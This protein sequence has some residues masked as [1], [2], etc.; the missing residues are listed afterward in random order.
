MK[1][2]VRALSFLAAAVMTGSALTAS[3]P[4][5]LVQGAAPA[6][7]QTERPKA[8]TER[9]APAAATAPQQTS[10]TVRTTGTVLTETAVTT[11]Q[12]APAATTKKPAVTTN[13]AVTTKPAAQT[14]R[15]VS[16]TRTTTTTEQTTTTVVT[17]VPAPP[18]IRMSGI[19]ADS[20]VQNTDEWNVSADNSALFFK[21]LDEEPENESG[22]G[23][24]VDR[25][26]QRW[27][28]ASKAAFDHEGDCWIHFWAVPSNFGQP[29]GQATF[30]Y[31]L[32]AT[33]PEAY[34]LTPTN[35]WDGRAY[36]EV[37]GSGLTD[38]VSG[39]NRIF[40]D[41]VKND[42]SRQSTG[43]SVDPVSAEDGTYSISHKI[44]DY[45]QPG[46]SLIFHVLDQAGN[47]RTFTVLGANDANKPVIS[48][49][50]NKLC[51]NRNQTDKAVYRDFGLYQNHKQHRAVFAGDANACLRVQVTEENLKK[52]TVRVYTLN[53]ETNPSYETVT[54]YKPGSKQDEAHEWIQK[55]KAQSGDPDV[56]FLPVSKLGLEEGSVYYFA[57]EAE[58]AS[59]NTSGF[60]TIMRDKTNTGYLLYDPKGTT[61]SVIGMRPDVKPVQYGGQYYYGADYAKRSLTVDLSDDYGIADYKVAVNGTEIAA[62]NLSGGVTTATYYT[63]VVPVTDESGEP[64]TD[65]DDGTETTV[66]TYTETYY[67]PVKKTS[68]SSLRLS[69]GDSPFRA[70]EQHQI[71]VQLNDLAGNKRELNYPLVIDTRAPSVQD[72]SYRYSGDLLHYLTF[73]I[74]GHEKLNL[75]IT[76]DDGRNGIGVDPEQVFLYWAPADAETDELT[77]YAPEPDHSGNVFRFQDLPLENEAIPYFTIAD[78]LGN[79]RT[80][81]FEIA[82]DD[83]KSGKLTEKA[84]DQKSL[85]LENTPPAVKLITPETYLPPET[86]AAESGLTTT[87]PSGTTT[88]PAGAA[89]TAPSGVTTSVPSGMTTTAPPAETTAAPVYEPG[90]DQLRVYEAEGARWYPGPVTVDVTARDRNS[91]IAEVL[92]Y[93]K[94]TLL[95]EETAFPASG[96]SE[97]AA[98]LYQADEEGNISF[99]ANRFVD[100]LLYHYRFTEEGSY[101]LRA[102]AYDNAGNWNETARAVIHL[103]LHN[104]KILRFRIGDKTAE[105]PFYERDTFGYFF[106]ED[107]DVRVYI[108]DE[109]VS[110]GFEAVELYLYERVKNEDGTY[111][112]KNPDPVTVSADKLERDEETGQL[113]A[114]FTVRRN[115]KGK[116]AAV[117]RDNVGHSSGLTYTDGNVLEDEEQHEKDSGITI[118]EQVRLEKRDAEGILLHNSSI[119]LQISVQDQYSGIA[120]ITWSVANDGKSGRIIVHEDGTYESDS[121][122]A[123]IDEEKIVR[124]QNLITELTFYV[125]VESNTNHNTVHVA[126]EDRAGHPCEEEQTYSIDTTLPEIRAVMSTENAEEQVY[127]NKVQTV[128]ISIQERNFD[129]NDV[130]VYINDQETGSDWNEEASVGTDQ[131]VHTGNFS[132]NAD[133]EY[134]FRIEYTDMAGNRG[135]TY[136]SHHFVIDTIAPQIENNFAA[137]SGTGKKPVY[138]NQSTEKQATAV[139][140]VN[141]K[142]FSAANMN[143]EV[144]RKEP[145]SAHSDDGWGTYAYA[146]PSDWKNDANNPDLHILEYHFAADGVYKIVM[147]PTDLAGNAGN[148]RKN[149]NAVYPNGSVVFEVD[150]TKP[151]ISERNN[152][153]VKPDDTAFCELYGYDERLRESPFVVFDDTNIERID[154]EVRR[155]TPV[156]QNQKQLL[157]VQPEQPDP[158][159][160]TVSLKQGDRAMI[161]TLPDFEKDG[162]YSVKLKAYDKAGNVSEV[163]DNTYIRMIRSDVLAY[164][165]KS[166]PEKNSGWYSFAEMDQD[167]NAHAISK[168]P[169]SFSDLS[170]V[171]LSKKKE[172][173][174]ILLVN[175]ASNA[176]TDTG[177]TDDPEALFDDTMFDAGAYRYVLPGSYFAEHFTADADTGLYLRVENAGKTLDLGEIYIDNTDPECKIVQ[178]NFKN[179]GFLKGSGSRTLQ[180]EGLSETLDTERTVAYIDD[181][182]VHIGENTGFRYDAGQNLLTLDLEP[183]SHSVG[184]K[185]VDRAGNEIG[186]PEVQHLA[187]GMQGLWQNYGLFAVILLLA[188][189]GIIFGRMFALR[190][191]RR[192]A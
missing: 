131:T 55:A 42:G 169:D 92:L 133:G 47:D 79:T 145:G 105:E 172:P 57:V 66:S 161:Y 30:H 45:I 188:V 33:P 17:T 76:L 26:V 124:D 97:S 88:V 150:Y 168:Q 183:G 160:G 109:G 82:H 116:L 4:V 11:R 95:A 14:T 135:T 190:A 39:I 93:E 152:G 103:D 71:H 35:Q 34:T 186:I 91:G 159:K 58:D 142:N 70:N 180:F 75:E 8:E 157:A 182:T 50:V 126:L 22:W 27:N 44:Y 176:E 147:N 120:E 166:I 94:D 162:I 137:F 52:L 54:F 89:T 104:P 63:T 106:R 29:V 123:V 192:L 122:D 112:Y 78:R 98:K 25:R 24:Y 189:L 59:K 118:T 12:T 163:N 115:F 74:F 16:V 184:I 132:I 140:R 151:V 21:V 28:E 20:W 6:E 49:D 5:Q 68:F 81:Y 175:K 128:Q 80:Y 146:K 101:E 38:A 87:A 143:L 69:G 125:T 136:F 96:L 53:A 10:D 111:S 102:R 108:E 9:P 31:K 85:I 113:Y 99:E 19:R 107:T 119:P 191:K 129:P 7:E 41:I 165:E 178:K 164:I 127:L 77:Q 43:V 56:Y 36:L 65:E 60:K 117:V 51:I 100:P 73:G 155:Y 174:R 61:D 83:E 139:I 153:A 37:S 130:K 170:I 158:A 179:W 2:P 48:T 23:N 154:Y 15:P 32:D 67:V 62:E 148:F 18:Q 185:L 121:E 134:S 3:I 64:V 90:A 138:F 84:M 114:K 86:T 156:Y 13:P 187:V 40:Y 149:D 1:I 110:S 173:S 72:S 141:E 167:G 46:S 144:W 177:I 171:V 181:R